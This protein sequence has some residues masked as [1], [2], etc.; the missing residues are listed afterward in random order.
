MS[1]VE[2]ISYKVKE[3]VSTAKVVP[4][5]VAF[6]K[7]PS[8]WKQA[9]RG[10]GVVVAV[11]DSGCQMDHPA[12]QSKIIGGYNFTKDYGS[13]PKNFS[14]NSGHGTH[15][16]GTIA[17]GNKSANVVGVAPGVKLL[18]LKVVNSYG[19]GETKW[20]VR[21][22]DYAIKWRGPNGERV[23]VISMSLG[24]RDNDPN[25]HRAVKDAI[26]NNIVFVCA[27]GNYGNTDLRNHPIYP[28]SYKEVI[29]VGSINLDG[30]ISDFS[31]SNSGIALYAPGENILST[32]P[33]GYAVLSGTSM[34]TPHVSG[35]IALLIQYYESYLKRKL[36]VSEIYEKLMNRTIEM[37][38]ASRKK[39]GYR[40]L[41]LT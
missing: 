27:A 39:Q 15:V 11:L 18:V 31:N 2:L 30:E 40:I 38:V 34:A 29:Q 35:S 17:A 24:G 37:P 23:R 4:S 16:C 14:D 10:N 36:T 21:A 22:I 26:S 5:G 3:V 12:L 33:N 28:G 6:I 41:R 32:H 25:L 13:D 8:F 9:I 1:Q 7:A 20:A 19:K